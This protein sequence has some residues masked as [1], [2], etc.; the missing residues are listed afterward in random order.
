MARTIGN[1]LSWTAQVLGTG[2]A[3]VPDRLER[4]GGSAPLPKVAKLTNR[5][6]RESLKAGYD[7][8]TAF[9]TDVMFAC[10]IYPV[11]GLVLSFFAFHRALLPL[12]FPLVA[13]FALLGPVAAIGLYEMSRRRAAGVEA[14]WSDGFAILRSPSLAPIVA[15]GAV[16][17]VLFLCWLGAAGLIYNATLGPELPASLPALIVDA[18]TTPAGWT[19]TIVG[20]A[21]GFV[22]AAIVLAVSAM[23]L[24]LLVDRDAGLAPAIV[25]S[26]QVARENPRVIA[27]W[28]LIVAVSLAL[29]ALPAFLGL[30]VV[31]PILGHATWHLYRRALVTG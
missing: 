23:S 3:G 29:G 17:F 24:P 10:L 16:L 9:R 18:L 14:R 11:I 2:A 6:L 25:L 26:V 19:M 27:T 20:F 21:V 22:F 5:D 4:L 12:L 31:M 28:G 7:D 8:F 30:I 1:P 13:G 15:V